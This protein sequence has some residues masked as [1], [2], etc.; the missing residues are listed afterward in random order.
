MERVL[1]LLKIE[2]YKKDKKRRES[3]NESMTMKSEKVRR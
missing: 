1:V 2:I 3:R